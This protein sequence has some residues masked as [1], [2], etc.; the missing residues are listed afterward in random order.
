MFMKTTNWEK[1]GK[2]DELFL[3]LFNKLDKLMST[4]HVNGKGLFETPRI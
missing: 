1:I 3:G 4:L 2:F